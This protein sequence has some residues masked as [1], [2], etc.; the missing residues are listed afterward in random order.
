MRAGLLIC[1]IL[2]SANVCAERYL[3]TEDGFGNFSAEPAED[4]E[5]IPVDAVVPDSSPP[6]RK[7]YLLLK[8]L[9]MKLVSSLILSSSRCK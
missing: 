9:S 6:L 3:V 1:A 2:I 7:K 8:V 4:Q 5:A